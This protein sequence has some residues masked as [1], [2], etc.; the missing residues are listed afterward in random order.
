[1]RVLLGRTVPLLAV[2]TLL[3]TATAASG[4]HSF[5]YVKAIET[6]AN[7]DF[8]GA[9]QSLA[10]LNQRQILNEAN[11]FSQE[12]ID[13]AALWLPRARRAAML[14]TE[15]WFEAGEFGI[16]FRHVHYDA[17]RAIVRAIDRIRAEGG[18]VR[19]D[20]RFVRDW[21]LVTV[22]HLH[23]HAGVARSRPLLVE[24]RRIFPA[25]PEV[26]LA[27]GSDHEM[28]AF[29]TTGYLPQ[30]DGNGE[31]TGS[32]KVDTNK[33]LESAARFYRDASLLVEARLRLGHV[34]FRQGQM[35][36]ATRELEAARTQG[37]H[38][39]LRY[40]AN[41][42]LGLIESAGGRGARATEFYSEA[43]RLYPASQTALLGMSEVAYLEGRLPDAASLMTKLLKTKDKA[44]PW[45]Q[46]MQGEFW[47]REFRLTALRKGVRQ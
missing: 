26:L 32:E 34:L 45:W 44:D 17:A 14:H 13:K 18:P 23:G 22:S 5:A 16:T 2:A 4:Q 19:G 30:Y 8:A 47:H 40:L 31:R 41:V 28:V 43:L 37:G 1:M 7:G 3:G 27:S 38:P 36:A 24:A 25:D 12:P 6:Y 11:R 9:M 15:A 10:A 42:F 29:I 39:T 20:P 35:E 46:Y 33:E 21:Y